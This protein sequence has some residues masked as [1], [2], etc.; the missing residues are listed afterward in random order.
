MLVEAAREDAIKLAVAICR[1]EFNIRTVLIGAADAHRV[2]DLLASKGVAVI[3]GP[4]MIRT[5]EHEEVNLPMALA[6][7]GAPFGFQSQ[8]TSGASLLADG[9]GLRRATRPGHRRSAARLDLDAG[10]SSRTRQSGHDRDRQRRGYGGLRRHAIRTVYARAGGDDRWAVGVHRIGEPPAS[11][12]R[13]AAVRM[14]L[15]Q[16]GDDEDVSF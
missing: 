6:V 16:Q 11:A 3:T 4:D 14:P 8:A 2:A 1:D 5:V 13:S 12:A 7:R 15:M 10:R 9:R